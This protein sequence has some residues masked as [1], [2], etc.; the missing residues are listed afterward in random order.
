MPE[1]DWELI[2]HKILAELRD[3]VHTLK[4]KMSQPSTRKDMVMAMK[5]LRASID[6]MHSIFQTALESSE[7]D[8]VNKRLS[9][10]EKQ[11]EQIARA[12]VTVA[13]LVEGITGKHLSP[14]QASVTPRPQTSMQSRMAPPI[15]V[16]SRPPVG[17]APMPPSMRPPMMTPSAPAPGGTSGMPPPPPAPT[18]KGFFR[19]K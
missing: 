15:Q 5:D 9:A 3:E 12:L 17:M 10:I 8:E 16:A 2:P 7:E 18:K 1:E 4:D 14:H 6:K 11:N 19:R 13:D